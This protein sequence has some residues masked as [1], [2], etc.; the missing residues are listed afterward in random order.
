MQKSN[1]FTLIELVV[2]IVILGI[3]SV[4][5]A[6]RFLNLQSD[7][8][9]AVL[10]GVKGSVTGANGIVY[11]KAAIG[12]KESQERAVVD[13]SG[14]Q[15]LTNYGHIL[16]GE[17]SNVE[18]AVSTD[19]EMIELV[20]RGENDEVTREGVV[21]HFGKASLTGEEAVKSG[22]YLYSANNAAIEHY[23]TGNIIYPTELFFEKEVSGC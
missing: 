3:L 4:T 19:V 12:G 17:V 6:P 7:A 14:E 16:M 5:A 2:V 23:E 9:S 1:G 13:S 21:F 8:R 15:I 11:G 22:C 20:I 10:D 18:K